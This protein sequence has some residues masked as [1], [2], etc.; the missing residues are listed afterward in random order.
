MVMK[1]AGK[2]RIGISGWRYKGWRG[3]F[4]PPKLTQKRELEFAS[5]EFA[6]IEINGSFYSLQRPESFTRWRDETP[7]DF[8]FSVK[9][10]RYITHLRRLREIRQPL[11][12][13]FAQGLLAL[14]EKLGPILWQFPPN[15]QF[16][17]ER[18]EAFFKLLPRSTGAAA[19]LARKHDEWMNERS[20][21]R[22]GH[23]RAL[24]HCV[25]IRNESFAV[26]EFV[27]LLREHG[28]GLVVADTVEW[29]LLMDVTSDFVYCRLHGSEQLYASGY[30]E[31]ALKKWA[32][33]V[34]AWARGG[35]SPD[36]KFAEPE[37]SAPRQPRDVYV[38]FDNDAKVRAPADARS[39]RELVRKRLPG[40]LAFRPDE[41]RA[42]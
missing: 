25:E 26:P 19:R 35:N 3:V 32:T 2:V 7:D 11:A 27:D 37:R 5:R 34:S 40:S 21:T 16:E 28:I 12:N 17:P 14:E 4:Y 9:G 10:S 31:A 23:D 20:L 13:F 24:R 6:T 36:G 30:T 29:P 38:Y 41:S 42:A 22:A 1:R 15:F 33:R 8:A 18:F 39:L